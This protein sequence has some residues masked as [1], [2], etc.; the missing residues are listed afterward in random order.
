M[1][2][3]YKL[4]KSI[5]SIT[6]T[7]IRYWLYFND[8]LSFRIEA[9]P[10]TKNFSIEFNINDDFENTISF[11]LCIPPLFSFY[12]GI[13]KTPKKIIKKLIGY[14]YGNRQTGIRIFDWS[15]WLEFWLGED[16]CGTLGNKWR[17]FKTVFHPVNYILGKIKYS[18]E[19]KET[20]E[21]TFLV[22]E[23]FSYKEKEYTGKWSKEVITHKRSRW[24]KKDFV[25]YELE[26][27]EGVPFPGKGTAGYN[28]DEDATYSLSGVFNSKEELV[29]R[30]IKGI[31][32]NRENYPL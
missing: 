27:E 28:C 7:G 18:T 22:P 17:G 24:F 3:N 29:D 11:N 16:N 32:S 31:L 9:Y 10:F 4:E 19:V 21:I 5:C 15:I 6:G 2:Q 26:V 25:R 12:F 20:G 14:K 23:G 1:Y 13:E 8:N 30:F